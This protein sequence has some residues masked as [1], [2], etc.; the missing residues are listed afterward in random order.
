MNFTPEA[1]RRHHASLLREVVCRCRARRDPSEFNVLLGA[2][3]P[4]MIDLPRAVA[5][6]D[7][8]HA[9]GM[10]LHEVANLRGLFGRLASELLATECG[11]ET[12]DTSPARRLAPAADPKS[13]LCARNRQ[14]HCR[15]RAP[16]APQLA[17]PDRRVEQ[18]R[19][20]RPL[21]MPKREQGRLN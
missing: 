17:S 13:A 11:A 4:V 9:Q 14:S 19:F 1:A 10:L 2:D 3:G 12:W 5:A 21:A 20:K 16:L 15:T 18:I 8:N 6:T 7:N